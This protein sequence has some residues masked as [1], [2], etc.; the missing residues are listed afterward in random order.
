MGAEVSDI[1]QG[2]GWWGHGSSFRSLPMVIRA[3]VLVAVAS[4]A[5]TA[6]S[7]GSSLS[8]STTDPSLAIAAA[9]S[10]TTATAPPPT[11]PPTTIPPP[12]PTTTTPPTT[13]PPSPPTTTTP[14]APV[15]SSCS[16][17]S[18]GGNCYEPGEYCRNSDHGV[19]GVAGDGKSI[20]CED[21]NGWRWEPT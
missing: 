14:P 18:N 3:G 7:G 9:P 17:L 4:V 19:S 6:C 21:N 13:I 16:P 11:A 5:L 2:R 15:A 20:M 12:P 8:S 1:P 10:N